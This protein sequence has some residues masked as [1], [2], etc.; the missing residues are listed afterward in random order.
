[1]L[2]IQNDNILLTRGDAAYLDYTFYDDSGQA[3]TLAGGD[4]AVLSVRAAPKRVGE[5]APALC[6]IEYNTETG[7]FKFTSAATAA[8]EYGDYCYDVEI[9]MANGDVFTTSYGTLTLTYEV[10]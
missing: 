7:Q 2:K 9:T 10:T 6:S 4:S 3:Y 5:T 1:M 8:M